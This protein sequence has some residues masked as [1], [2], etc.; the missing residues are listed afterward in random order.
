MWLLTTEG[1]YSV[2]QKPE[3]RE[4]SSLTVRARAAGDLD[5]LRVMLPSLGPTIESLDTD[6]R[7][8]AQVPAL[9]LGVL[10]AEL[11]THINYDNFK[12]AV[13]RRLG[14][15]RAVLYHEVWDVLKD[16]QKE[17]P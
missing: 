13:G 16:L 9:E 10:M 14:P 4:T 2:V 15:G 5:R 3:D 17:T 6:Y 12:R 7:W 8:R 11:I 1:F